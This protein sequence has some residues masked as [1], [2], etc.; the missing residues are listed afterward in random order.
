MSPLYN[1]PGNPGFVSALINIVM[2][3]ENK[4][5][6]NQKTNGA[7]PVQEDLPSSKQR[8]MGSKSDLAKNKK[9]IK[10]ELA[11]DDDRDTNSVG[12]FKKGKSSP[13]K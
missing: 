9:R 7:K 3:H 2:K 12:I 11:D 13:V 1:L 5:A 8:P 4:N 6:M 10:E